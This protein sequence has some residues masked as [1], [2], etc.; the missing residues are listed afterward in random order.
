MDARDIVGG[1]LGAANFNF[2]KEITCG[3]FEF[4]FTDSEGLLS[5]FLLCRIINPVA[6]LDVYVLENSYGYL[7]LHKVVVWNKKIISKVIVCNRSFVSKELFPKYCKDMLVSYSLGHMLDYA[8]G[9]FSK[10]SIPKEV[11]TITPP[12]PLDRNKE[13]KHPS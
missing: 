11:L 8:T 7:S 1:I 2:R 12:E 5:V 13:P 3:S 9:L 4:S 6:T 10:I